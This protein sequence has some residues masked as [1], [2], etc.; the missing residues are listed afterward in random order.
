MISEAIEKAGYKVGDDIVFALDSASSE[1]Y[2]NGMYVL[3]NEKNPNK[4]ASDLVSFYEDLKKKFPIFSIE[5][6][7]AQDDWAGWKILTDRL[8]KT[9]QLVGDDLFVTNTKRLERGISQKTGNSILIKVNQIG[10]LTETFEAI[11]MAHSAGYTTV[12]SHR[13]GETE[14]STIAD[15]AVGT[16]SGQIKTGSL[17]RTDRVCKYN[18]LLRIEEELGE[19]AVYPGRSILK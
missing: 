9:T 8:G 6:G 7:L 18:Q 16:K 10:T 11:R 2:K 17:C 3:E 1:F 12:M 15:L 13:S 5:D 14:D 4:S 19:K